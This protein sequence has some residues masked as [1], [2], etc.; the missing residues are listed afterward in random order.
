MHCFQNTLTMVTSYMTLEVALLRE[1]EGTVIT[2]K[3]LLPRVCTNMSLKV[4]L[5]CRP[6]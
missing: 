4:I 3:G 6:E 1:G 5:L 2:G